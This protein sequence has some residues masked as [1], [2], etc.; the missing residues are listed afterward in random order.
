MRLA[1]LS[2]MTI[3]QTRIWIDCEPRSIG[4]RSSCN[5]TGRQPFEAYMHRFFRWL[6]SVHFYETDD[7]GG[8]MELRFSARW[9]WFSLNMLICMLAARPKR[10]DDRDWD[11]GWSFDD[12]A[13]T[14]TW[15]FHRLWWELPFV[16]LVLVYHQVLSIDGKR[17]MHTEPRRKWKLIPQDEAR[18]RRDKEERIKKENT[19]TFDY[20]Y[21]MH[22]GEVQEVKATI[23]ASRVV[24][25][26]KW[27]PFRRERD[28]IWVS[29]SGEVGPE[30]GSW[31][32]GVT[33]CGWTMKKGEAPVQCLRRMERER[34][35]E[36]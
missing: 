34:R 35:F 2:F 1:R 17:V 29:F 26:W 14:L 10:L 28:Q 23:E 31:K 20:R 33:G 24:H 32:G 11:W 19:A 30:R 15:G 12:D 6:P 18:R 7:E 16:S 3:A 25:R 27:T 21:E 8:D 13:L 4:I 22:T 36:R 5:K 9:L